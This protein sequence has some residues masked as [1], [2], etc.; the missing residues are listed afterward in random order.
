MKSLGHGFW[1]VRVLRL[2]IEL[3][4]DFLAVF[5]AI[6]SATPGGGYCQHAVFWQ[7][8][9]PAFPFSH[10]NFFFF[11]SLCCCSSYPRDA[12]RFLTVLSFSLLLSC[13]LTLLSFLFSLSFSLSSGLSFLH[14]IKRVQDKGKRKKVIGDFLD[15]TRAHLPSRSS[16]LSS[17][18]HPPL[19]ICLFLCSALLV[20]CC[21]FTGLSLTSLQSGQ[22]STLS[23]PRSIAY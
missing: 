21:C 5:F 10:Q 7:G 9:R 18:R 23:G 20:F 14:R 13:L 15:T 1:V 3:R 8:T 16:I 12:H 17:S 4:I 19:S 22:S 2:V 6:G 11:F